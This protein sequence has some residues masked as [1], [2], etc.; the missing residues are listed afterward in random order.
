MVKEF[1]VDPEQVRRHAGKVAAVRDQ[2]T[3]VKSASRAISQDDT[4]Y[5]LLCGWIAGIL[6]RRHVGQD[7]LYAYVQ[8][9]LELAVD[10]LTAAAGEYEAVDAAAQDRIRRAGGLG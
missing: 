5:G 6:E 10:A 3:A 7:E 1:T 2:L 4:A 9:N 8:E